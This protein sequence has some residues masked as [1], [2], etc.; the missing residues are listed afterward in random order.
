MKQ[1]F[2]GL[3]F[4]FGAIG[5]YLKMTAPDPIFSPKTEQEK[6]TTTEEKYNNPILNDKKSLE[7]RI[8]KTDNSL[9]WNNLNN[10]EIKT[11]HLLKTHSPASISKEIQGN[12]PK[13]I[14]CLNEDLCGMKPSP[15]KAYF[16][17]SETHSH[18]ILKRELSIL[19]ELI[20]D[21]KVHINDVKLPYEQLISLKNQEIK[22]LTIDLYTHDNTAASFSQLLSISKDLTNES[23]AYLYS[24]AFQN[25]QNKTIQN[26]YFQSLLKSIHSK[27]S[28]EVTLILEQSKSFGL[29]QNQFEEVI[30][31][32]CRFKF[33]E[34]ESQNWSE[35]RY[36]LNEA[37]KLQNYSLS[38]ER[39]CI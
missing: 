10:Y 29:S 17:N 25:I 15:G 11:D 20:E 34:D 35:V 28:F 4:L 24:K 9:L 21:R 33:D 39:I 5:S 6:S 12:V 36:S 23:K 22:K 37:I 30:K 31:N 7:Q 3:L 2:I 27:N 32:S 8:E 18:K 19:N 1:I 38:V 26:E 16:D 14:N 13:I